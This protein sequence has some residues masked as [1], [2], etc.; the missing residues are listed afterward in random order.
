MEIAANLE[1]LMENLI[2]SDRK[3]DWNYIKKN[4]D[5]LGLNFEEIK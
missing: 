5:K 3:I 4:A 2:N 1:K